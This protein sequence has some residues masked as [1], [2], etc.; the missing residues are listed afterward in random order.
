VPISGIGINNI[1]V[2][3]VNVYTFPTPHAFV[4]YQ[5]VTV[6]IGTPIV[7]VP[8]CVEAHEFS[9]RN[10][11]IIKDDS[12][13][14]R[15]FCDAGVPSFNAMNYE[16]EQ[17]LITQSQQLPV[18]APPSVPETKVPETPKVEGDPPCPGPNAL[19]VGDIATNQKEKVSGHELRINPQNPGGAKICVTLYTDIPPVEQYLPS[20]QVASTTAVIA[21]TAATSALLAKPL[22]DLILRVVKPAVK[23]MISKI[24]TS[25]GK[26]PQRPSRDLVRM[27]EYRKKKGLPPLKPR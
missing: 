13:T 26:T 25:V 11:K 20:T 2:R 23:K 22:A 5:P 3:D 15:T 17:L 8:G 4:P 27:N 9:D 18:V 14:V 16:P 7:N 12:S 19:R 21:A 10:N 24:Q 6:E 1:R